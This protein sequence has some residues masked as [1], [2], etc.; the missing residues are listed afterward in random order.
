MNKFSFEIKGT[1]VKQVFV[2]LALATAS[3]F[4]FG[5]TA[6][7]KVEPCS[8]PEYRQFEFWVGS[9]DVYPTGK[10]N[11]V[12]HS[13]IESVYGGCGIRENWMPLSGADGG[14]LSSYVS[15]ESAWR[16]TWIDSR[17]ARV[18]FKGGWHDDAMILEG[19]WRDVLGPGKDALV[20]MTYTKAIDSSVRQMGEMSQDGGETWAPGFDFT[21]KL[22]KPR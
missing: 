15:R 10:D 17:G 6:E 12:A 7:E 22:A 19:L 1:N 14:S 13:L 11:L 20:R 21:Y 4:A 18:D 16:Q 2:L 5:Q 9:W 8:A 3:P